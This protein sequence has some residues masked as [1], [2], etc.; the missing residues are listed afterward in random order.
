MDLLYYLEVIFRLILASVLGGIVGAERESENK[1]AGFRTNILVCIASALTMI[2]SEYIFKKYSG[3]SNIDPARLG[4]Q[5]IS[6]IGFL[7]AGAIIR[8]GFGIKGLTTAASL[9]AVACVGL[10]C[11]I[12]FYEGAIFTTLIIIIVLFT[13]KKLGN[14]M[15][16]NSDYVLII[17]ALSIT[18]Q[19]SNITSILNKNNIGID[20]M[21]IT[22]D[23]NYI[24]KIVFK[25]YKNYTNKMLETAIEEIQMLDDINSVECKGNFSD[26]TSYEKTIDEMDI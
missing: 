20:K 10:A 6:G 24:I 5:V 7:G 3:L 14:K 12:G 4:A 15:K 2:T 11:G 16:H 17:N 9:W 22:E 19:I 1:N 23:K 26:A 25:I 13:L 8:D 21:M 18:Q